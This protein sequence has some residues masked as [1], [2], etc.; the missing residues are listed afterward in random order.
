M[1]ALY[2]FIAV[3]QDALFSCTDNRPY[4]PVT[5]YRV[6]ATADEN[7]RREANETSSARLIA[8]PVD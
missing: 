8:V 1:Y 3:A 6:T 2:G 7:R 5:N 4:R